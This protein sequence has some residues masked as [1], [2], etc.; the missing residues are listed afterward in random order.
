M[1]I[2]SGLLLLLYTREVFVFVIVCVC[3]S[4][5][6]EFCYVF[7]VRCLDNNTL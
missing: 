4:E 3:A 7:F 1:M 2:V 5:G 6:L